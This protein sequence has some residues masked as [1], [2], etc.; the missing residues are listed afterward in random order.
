MI[1][2]HL[3]K[4]SYHVVWI[5]VIH[6][7]TA[8]LTASSRKFSLSRMLPLDF[9]LEQDSNSASVA[10]ASC[11]TPESYLIVL[12]KNLHWTELNL[13]LTINDMPMGW[14][15]NQLN[16]GCTYFDISSSWS[17]STPR[18]VYFR[19]VLFFFF[20]NASWMSAASMSAYKQQNNQLVRIPT[21]S[22]PGRMDRQR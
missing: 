8:H 9:S 21:H 22:C 5:T 11:Q 18:Y 12:S 17:R 4:H 16:S 6:Y 20:S 10:L 2:P 3:S 1:W 19:K 7:S 13:G 15:R 14:F